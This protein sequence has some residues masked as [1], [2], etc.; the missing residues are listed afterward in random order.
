MTSIVL[1]ES[2]DV[3]QGL[4]HSDMCC[5]IYILSYHR[6]FAPTIQALYKIKKARR[7]LTIVVDAPT[8]KTYHELYPE[9]RII[10]SMPLVGNARLR[11]LYDARSKVGLS[12]IIML[13]DDLSSIRAMGLEKDTGRVVAINKIFDPAEMT[14]RALCLASVAALRVFESFPDVSYGALKHS[15]FANKISPDVGVRI[16]TNRFPSNAM[17]FD[18]NRF[19]P[20]IPREFLEQGED[21]AMWLNNLTEKKS[22]FIL[23]KICYSLSLKIPSCINYGPKPDRSSHI[24][25]A[26]KLYPELAPGIVPTKRYEDGRIKRV[27]LR[28]T[29]LRD[30]GK[31]EITLP[32]AIYRVTKDDCSI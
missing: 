11:A 22:S 6:P 26:K 30:Y 23:E 18:V 7:L 25:T 29:F 24:I 8:Y 31:E 2:Y 1:D 28:K 32:T 4:T 19:T 3:Y 27:G 17:L 13:D 16:N 12:H 9:A 20:D 21:L 15:F 5:P 10:T 14:Y